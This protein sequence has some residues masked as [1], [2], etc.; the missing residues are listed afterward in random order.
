MERIESL[1][2]LELVTLAGAYAA[3]AH[4]FQRRK[5]CD[6][7]YINHPLRVAAAVTRAG[8]SPEAIAAAL[9][10][11][12][13]EDTERTAA[14]L[15]ELF[16]ARVV[17]LVILL[18]QWWQE[19]AS[20]EVKAE[21]KPRYYEAIA[22]DEEAATVKLFDRADNLGDMTRMLPR[23]RDWAV[24]YLKKS[25]QEVEPLLLAT[26]NEMAKRAFREAIA[27]LEAALLHGVE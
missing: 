23:K 10:H 9:L 1:K 4:A 21:E 20:N 2:G 7:P 22:K 13:V 18:T 19:D 14:Q 25:K 12:V 27:S 26:S 6:D 5:G 3:E 8:L 15:K 16:P 17:Q 11:D 24:R